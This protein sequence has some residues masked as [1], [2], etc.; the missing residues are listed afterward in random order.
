MKKIIL[1][2]TLLSSFNVFSKEVEKEMSILSM[3]KTK[4]NFEVIFTEHNPI[5]KADHSFGQCLSEGMK[6]K[7]KVMIKYDVYKFTIGNCRVLE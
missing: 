1:V 2:L 4:A 7:K 6:S 5:F 3:K